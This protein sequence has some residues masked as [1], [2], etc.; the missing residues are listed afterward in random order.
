VRP[1]PLMTCLACECSPQRHLPTGTARAAV[2]DAPSSHRALECQADAFPGGQLEA[3]PQH[4]LGEAHEDRQCDKARWVNLAREG[5][6]TGSDSRRGAATPRLVARVRLTAFGCGPDAISRRRDRNL[7]RG[8]NL[9]LSSLISEGRS[10]HTATPALHTSPPEFAAVARVTAASDEHAETDE[11]VGAPALRVRQPRR[12]GP[13]R[14]LHLPRL[15][16]VNSLACSRAPI[17]VVRRLDGRRNG[18]TGRGV[19]HAHRRDFCASG[20]LTGA[21]ST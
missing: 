5:G 19:C 3:R 16:F 13:R 11:R 9:A 6:R 7:P 10:G 15:G 8:R 14:T 18:A 21:G 12:M 4:P 2:T 1:L 17:V 20:G